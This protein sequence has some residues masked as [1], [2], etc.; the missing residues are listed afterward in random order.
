MR[1]ALGLEHA[2]DAAALRVDQVQLDHRI[3]EKGVAVERLRR[4]LPDHRL[5]I[6]RQEVEEPPAFCQPPST[7]QPL[8][9]T[10]GIMDV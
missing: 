1:S 8:D 4:V 3:G 2:L 7:E 6:A 5:D 9:P 10:C